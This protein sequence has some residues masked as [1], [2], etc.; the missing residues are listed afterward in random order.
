MRGSSG[1]SKA[2]EPGSKAP[3]VL[4][5]RSGSPV[6]SGCADSSAAS[7]ASQGQQVSVR[8]PLPRYPSTLGLAEDPCR[9]ARSPDFSGFFFPLATAATRDSGHKF[10][11]RASSGGRGLAVGAGRAA[12]PDVCREA[13]WVKKR[14]PCKVGPDTKEP[15]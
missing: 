4:G 3:R 1:R 2:E 5:L 6:A 9:L 10:V 12:C 13:Q 11:G 7:P 15:N 8:A 14:R